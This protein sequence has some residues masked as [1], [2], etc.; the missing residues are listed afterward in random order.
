VS[1]PEAHEAHLELHESAKVGTAGPIRDDG[2]V[3]LH[4]IRPGIGKGRGRHLYEAK[5]LEE[6]AG[7]FKGWKMYVDHQSPEAKKAAG[8]LPR[9]LRDVGGII[10]ESWWDPNVPANPA[11]GHGQGAV[12]GL[13]RPTRLIKSLI[14]D[15]PALVECSIAAT[16]T[17]VRPITHGGQTA[18]LVEGLND[19][20]SVDWVTEAGAGG[21]V[22][23]LME[24]I[25]ESWSSDDELHEIFE[26]MTDEEAADHL[27]ATRPDL[28]EHLLETEAAPVGVPP[29]KTEHARST[30]EDEEVTITPEA[31]REALESPECKAIVETAVDARFNAIAAPKLALLVEAAL[32]DERELMQAEAEAT[33]DRK[34][35]LRDIRDEAHSTIKESKLPPTFQA[36]LLK[37]FDLVE[38][39]PTAELDVEDDRDEDGKLVKSASEKVAEAVAGAIQESRAMLAEARPT[40][41][42]AHSAPAKPKAKDDSEDDDKDKE[43]TEVQESTGS[44]KTDH[45]LQESGIAIDDD[46]YA[47]ITG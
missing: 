15:D 2:L 32:E 35:A 45:L 39:K 3:P 13:A 1:V 9:S 12:V 19:R 34:L 4:I 7:V 17:S 31:L 8:G 20:G 29:K 14:E 10:K 24:S 16:A 22:V 23:S 46:L 30:E 6:A 36:P 26:S 33:A 37:R 27:R 21:K 43:K 18:W 28:V 40:E 47:G 42:V 11:T 44:A 25:Q 5:M 41:H 38:G